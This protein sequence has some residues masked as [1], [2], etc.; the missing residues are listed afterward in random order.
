MKH[1]P[2]SVD[3]LTREDFFWGGGVGGF[4]SSVFRFVFVVQSLKLQ[5]LA[6]WLLSGNNRVVL[7]LY[8]GYD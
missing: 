2:R 4:C 1:V 3:L 5:P 6:L 7:L 8:N